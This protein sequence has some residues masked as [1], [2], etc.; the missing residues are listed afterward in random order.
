MPTKIEDTVLGQL[1]LRGIPQRRY[2]NNNY[3]LKSN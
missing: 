1:T 3:R 2:T